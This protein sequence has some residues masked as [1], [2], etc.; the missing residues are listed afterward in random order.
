LDDTKILQILKFNDAIT[1]EASGKFSS[2]T[3]IE[4]IDFIFEKTFKILQITLEII[5]VNNGFLS[6]FRNILLYSV[7]YCKKSFLHM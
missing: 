4:R 2:D 5:R 1:C 6:K 7:N 3:K